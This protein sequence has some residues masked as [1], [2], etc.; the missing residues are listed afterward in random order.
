MTDDNDRP[1]ANT[2]TPRRMAG[3]IDP[4]AARCHLVVGFD[5]HPGGRAAL[6]YAVGLAGRLDAFLHVAHI[7]DADDLPIDPD[8]AD[9]EQVVADAVKRERRDAC[10]VL[11]RIPGPWSYYNRTGRPAQILLDL[12][13]A[14][15]A[16]MIVVGTSRGGPASFLHRLLGDSVAADLIHHAHRPVLLVPAPPTGR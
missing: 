15:D 5:R 9:W 8:S 4:T 2:R 13:E 1:A 16:E 12:A 6:N 10:A 3:P 7:L 14:H 11:A